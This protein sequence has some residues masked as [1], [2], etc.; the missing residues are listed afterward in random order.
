[1]PFIRDISSEKREIR[2]L[3]RAQ[4][5]ALSY[6]DKLAAEREVCDE[7][8]ERL[9]AL[10]PTKGF[11]GLY[12]A[13]GS[14]LA[15]DRLAVRLGE[16]GYRIAYPAML[17]EHDMEFYTTAN[18]A[19]SELNSTVLLS[20]PSKVISQKKLETFRHIPPAQISALIAPA[21]AYDKQGY[22]LG[23]GGGY[24][25]RYLRKLSKQVPTWGAGF[26]L[27]MYDSLPVERHDIRL[28]SV[29]VA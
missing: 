6:E 13:M 15:L 24:Y 5:T 23:Q 28:K 25:D 10:D 19:I 29:I 27:Q 26:R 1:M 18:S 3:K 4:R 21:V 20:E 9:S 16:R 7:L 22:R 14:E 8:L 17:S 11:I 2:H 12:A